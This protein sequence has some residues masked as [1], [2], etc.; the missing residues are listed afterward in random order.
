MAANHW[1]KAIEV[2]RGNVPGARHAC[3][4]VS[5]VDPRR[6]PR[7][8]VVLASP[9][10]THHASAKGVSHEAQQPSLFEGPDPGAERSRA[11]MWDVHRF[12]ETHR[13][14]VSI[15]ENVVDAASWLYW[16]S[17]MSAW[18]DADYRLHRAI[19]AGSRRTGSSGA[20]NQVILGSRRNHTRWRRAKARVRATTSA[21][22]AAND[23]PSSR[24]ARTSL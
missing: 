18:S 9:E 20:A 6:Y 8:D 23:R 19:R 5:L 21:W 14:D 11:T 12:V 15:V 1:P 24:W 4:D 7:T 17:W 13:Y 22:H 10:C 16:P 2:H 3:A